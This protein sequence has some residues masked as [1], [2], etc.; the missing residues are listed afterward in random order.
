MTGNSQVPRWGPLLVVAV[1]CGAGCGR[2]ELDDGGFYGATGAAGERG[3]GGG[4]G[5]GGT[6]ASVGVGGRS[7]ACAPVTQALI[8]DF[9]VGAE[10]AM[11]E[12]QYAFAEAPLFLPALDAASGPL[13]ATFNTGV[14]TQP[15][16]YAGFGLAFPSCSDASA[17]AGVQFVM[18][19]RLSAGCTIQFMLEDRPHTS[20][21]DGVGT[22]T[23]PVCYSGSALFT[24]PATATEVT[25]LFSDIGAGSP[26]TPT[27]VPAEATAVQWLVNVPV[28]DGAVS[29]GCTGQV[30][31]DSVAFVR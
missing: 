16:A 13:T 24:L 1:A 22:C 31:I 18:S 7:G 20:P 6:T 27:V 26:A 2:E 23:A 25:I 29:G 3:S 5:T 4:S 9:T 17:F 14:P 19:G 30:T 21:G 8:E 12:A 28:G 11:V 15:Y 10:T